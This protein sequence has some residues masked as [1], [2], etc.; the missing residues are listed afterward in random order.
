MPH[1]ALVQKNLLGEDGTLRQSSSIPVRIHSECMTGDVFG[2]R[3]CECGE[4]LSQAMQVLGQEDS[5]GVLLYLRQEGRGIG[6]VEKLRAY[7]LQDEGLDTFAANRALGHADDSRDYGDAIAMLRDLGA[8]EIQLMT[9]NPDKLQA[10][11]DAGF[12]VT[13]IPLEIAPSPDNAEY[14]RAKALAGH[15]ITPLDLS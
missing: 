12:V 7:N 1:L 2:S 6:L 15:L 10:L 13:R 5:A 14:L 3:R 9:N 4:Q 11:S 8:H